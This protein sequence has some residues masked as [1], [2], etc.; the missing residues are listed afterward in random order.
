VSDIALTDEIIEAGARALAM[1]LPNEEWPT[2]AALGG[3][4][5]GTRDDEYR[6]AMREQSHMVAAAI[7]PLI[8]AAVREQIARDIEAESERRDEPGLR[9]DE[10]YTQRS[11]RVI[12]ADGMRDAAR[13][14]RG[15]T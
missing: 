12:T 7:A 9:L 5:T 14:A 10:S 6:A 1:L 15:D 13:I 2:N 3:S 8:E 11:V 4:M